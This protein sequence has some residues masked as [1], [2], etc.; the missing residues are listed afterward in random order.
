MSRIHFI[1][2]ISPFEEVSNSSVSIAGNRCQIGILDGLKKDNEIVQVLSYRPNRVFPYTN[3]IYVPSL[4][5]VY[6]GMNFIFLPYL[7]LPFFRATLVNLGVIFFL[8]K[9]VKKHDSLLFYNMYLPFPIGVFIL[10]K[11]FDIK[12]YILACDIHIPGQTVPNTMRWRYEYLK[13]KFFLQKVD[14]VIAV[15]EKILLDFKCTKKTMVMEGGI[16]NDLL[17]LDKLNLNNGEIFKIFYAGA[18]DKLNGVD[19]LIDA[20]SKNPNPNIRLI[21]AGKGELREFVEESA[22]KNS[23]IK[24]LG[25]IGHDEIKKIYEEISLLLCIRVTKEINTGYF[26]PSKLIEYIS[27]GIPVLCTDIK[28]SNFDLNDFC[29]VIKDETVEAIGIAINECIS[30]YEEIIL[31]AKRGK[32]YSRQEMI[33]DVQGKKISALINKC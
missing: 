32:S 31:K 18:L 25:L 5:A 6:K 1:G 8:F 9:K 30:N 17:L 19:L 13:H 33:W 15:S 3:K 24:F 16:P 29:F 28:S 4:Q 14:G 7:N 22:K 10:R 11:L 21:I 27:T 26:F 23:K 12:I 2:S 20:F